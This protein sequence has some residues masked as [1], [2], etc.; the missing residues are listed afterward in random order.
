[1]V[2]VAENIS[3]SSILLSSTIETLTEAVVCPG[4]KV[5][6]SVTGTKSDP[7]VKETKCT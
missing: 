1:M 6:V 4:T 5:N 2:N 3:V 7:S